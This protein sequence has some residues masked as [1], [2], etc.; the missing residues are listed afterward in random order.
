MVLGGM[1]DNPNMTQENQEKTQ[2]TGH[3]G[4]KKAKR[5]P[6][7]SSTKPLPKY[8]EYLREEGYRRPPNPGSRVYGFAAGAG[9]CLVEGGST[10][11]SHPTRFPFPAFPL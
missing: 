6:D 7:N 5:K 9:A 8:T 4:W 10:T 2:R 3:Y 11:A 1:P